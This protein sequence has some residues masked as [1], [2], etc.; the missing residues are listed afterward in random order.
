MSKNIDER[1]LKDEEVLAWFKEANEAILSNE[2]SY[3]DDI[4]AS[5][6]LLYVE[7]KCKAYLL[8]KNNKNGILDYDLSIRKVCYICN[9]FFSYH[10]MNY[11]IDKNGKKISLRQYLDN[12]PKDE[13]EKLENSF[14]LMAK[15]QYGLGLEE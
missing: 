3:K 7:E 5:L 14:I 6:F 4:L 13:K 12:L 10:L 1:I 9:Q 11:G 8:S 2:D 15:L